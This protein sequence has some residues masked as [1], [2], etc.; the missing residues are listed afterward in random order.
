[1]AT[2]L[3]YEKPG[4]ANNTRQKILL[5]AAGHTVQ[6]KSLLTEKWTA[7]RLRMFFGDLP[8]SDWFNLSAPRIRDGEVDYTR[9]TETEALVLMLA[10]PLLIRRPLMEIDGDYRVG[11]DPVEVD[12]WIGLGSKID[13]TGTDF[14]TCTRQARAPCPPPAPA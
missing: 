5:A 12:R 10:D 1:M 13:A 6:A 2:L 7:Q 4:C 14:E 9:I 11:F 8:V 3:F